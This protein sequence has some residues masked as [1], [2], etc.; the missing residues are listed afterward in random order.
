MGIIPYKRTFQKVFV[1]LTIAFLI[2][3]QFH[4]IDYSSLNRSSKCFGKGKKCQVTGWWLW[5]KQPKMNNDYSVSI[6][7]D[8]IKNKLDNGTFAVDAFDDLSY[9]LRFNFRKCSAK[10]ALIVDGVRT[11]QIHK[12]SPKGNS[13]WVEVEYNITNILCRFKVNLANFL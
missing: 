2:A 6:S 13:H 4:F 11:K 7:F 8:E 12:L 1:R 9:C 10:V 3:L 5:L